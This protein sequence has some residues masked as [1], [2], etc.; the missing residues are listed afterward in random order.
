MEN[1][2]SVLRTARK[3]LQSY[4]LHSTFNGSVRKLGYTTLHSGLINDLISWKESGRRRRNVLTLAWS[5]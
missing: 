3:T 2:D 5:D 4:F 1:S